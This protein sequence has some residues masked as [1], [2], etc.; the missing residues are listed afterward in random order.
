MKNVLIITYFFG[1]GKT[2]AGLRPLGLAKYLPEFGWKAIILTAKSNAVQDSRFDVIETKTSDSLNIVKKLL[3]MD[4][5]QTLMAQIAQLKKLLR[6]KKENSWFDKLLAL[7]GEVAAY[8]DFQKGWR[9]TAVRS[10]QTIFSEH[11]IKALISISPPVTTHIVAKELKEQFQIPWIAD[12]RDLWT[13]NQ[14]YPYSRIR[15]KREESL[16]LKTL[17]DADGLVTV[18]EPTATELGT[19]HKNKVTYSIPNGFDPVEMNHTPGRLTEKFTLTYTGNIYPGKQSPEPLFSALSELVLQGEIIADDIEVRF[20]GSELNW[21]NELVFRYG[22]DTVVKQY[23]RVDRETA[24][25]KQKESRVLIL[26]KWNDP[27]Q[28][29]ITPA[30][31]FEY[32]AAKRPVLTIGEFKDVTDDILQETNAGVNVRAKDNL[33]DVLLNLYHEYKQKGSIAYN[34]SESAINRYS[35]KEMA[36]KFAAILDSI[37]D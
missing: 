7:T 11:D 13:Q 21:I 17:S 24:V 16:E 15:K 12:F 2:V 3:K 31:I 8:P 20:Y 29:G 34:G 22:L 23:G 35:H 27:A 10:S 18:S 19:L 9:K 14:Y 37:T 28:K 33:R 6:I 1:A 26:L 5:E 36:R 25:R 30:K 4:P 32:L